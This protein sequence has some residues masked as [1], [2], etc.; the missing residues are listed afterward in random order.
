MLDDFAAIYE[1]E[2]G[3][4]FAYLLKCSR[5]WHVAEDLTSEVFLAAWEARERYEDRGISYGHYLKR[6]AHWRHGLHWKKEKRRQRRIHRYP[7]LE[8]HDRD[9]SLGCDGGIETVLDQVSNAV[10][11]AFL[12]AALRK[13][14]P[15][16]RKAIVLRY[17]LGLPELE[18]ARRM[19]MSY[20]AY[21]SCRKAAIERL[22][23]IMLG[24]EPR[25][26]AKNA[27]RR[28]SK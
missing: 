13:L 6:I 19:G 25:W 23:Q 7:Y 14:R 5:N 18:A 11:Y 24:R 16:P 26:T 17:G 12:E 2:R 15:R 21:R 20:D 27:R 8:Q 9:G 28:S 22:Q 4:V 1:Q 3:W 10:A